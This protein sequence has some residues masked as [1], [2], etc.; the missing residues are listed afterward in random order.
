MARKS[1]TIV[2]E[3]CLYGSDRCGHG[4]LAHLGPLTRDTVQFGDG[5]PVEGRSA[6]SALWLA[7]EALRGAG[8]TSGLVEVFAPGGEFEAVCDVNHPGYFGD[9]PWKRARVYVIDS[10]TLM[11]AATAAV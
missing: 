4:F 7:C 8:A 9:L 11:E 10:E 6:T 5:D 1:T 3:I 2:G